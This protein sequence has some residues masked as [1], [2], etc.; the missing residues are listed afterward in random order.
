MHSSKTDPETTKKAPDFKIL[1]E[2]ILEYSTTSSST[3]WSKHFKSEVL[4]CA[5]W[6]EKI[7]SYFALSLNLKSLWIGP[8][9]TWNT[10]V[11]LKKLNI[12]LEAKSNSSVRKFFSSDGGSVID[13]R[14][15]KF[16][17]GWTP[18]EIWKINTRIMLCFSLQINKLWLSFSL[19]LQNKYLINYCHKLTAALIPLPLQ[20]MNNTYRTEK[21]ASHFRSAYHW[22]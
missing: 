9:N 3:M 4:K 8:K 5:L 6:G 2:T 15:F 22:K 16:W 11:F 19:K 1:K 14:L 10:V 7:H 18:R 21:D 20:C 17:I 13:P 12:I